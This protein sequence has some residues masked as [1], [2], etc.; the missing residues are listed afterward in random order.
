[1]VNALT[2]LFMYILNNTY[3]L[4][5]PNIALECLTLLLLIWEVPGSNLSY[6]DRL[7]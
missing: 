5:V 3:Q 2:S 6:G 1:M 7:F 4:L